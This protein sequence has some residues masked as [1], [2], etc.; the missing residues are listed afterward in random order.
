VWYK[1]RDNFWLPASAE[2]LAL[3]AVSFIYVVFDTFVFGT[4]V[5]CPLLS[6]ALLAG[7]S[8][9]API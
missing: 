7:G 3:A 8:L 1:Y 2:A 9:P 4:V 5:R 6:T